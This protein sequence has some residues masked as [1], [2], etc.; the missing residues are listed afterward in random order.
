MV[1]VFNVKYVHGYFQKQLLQVSLFIRRY[2][3]C[4]SWAT[5]VGV[6]IYEDGEQLDHISKCYKSAICTTIRVGLAL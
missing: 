3:D 4:C 5:V 1:A 2:P 6:F